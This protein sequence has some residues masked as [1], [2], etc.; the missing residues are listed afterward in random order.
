[1]R[2]PGVHRLRDRIAQLTTNSST[3]MT[4]LSTA[5]AAARRPGSNN[6]TPPSVSADGTDILLTAPAGTVRLEGA[7]C[8]ADLCESTGFAD[9]LQQALQNLA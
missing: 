1:M 5:A 8:G 7:S 3:L 6:R 9:R 4:A 2:N